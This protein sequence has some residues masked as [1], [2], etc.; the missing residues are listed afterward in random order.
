MPALAADCSAINPLALCPAHELLRA[1][2]LAFSTSPRIAPR[3]R[4]VCPTLTTDLTRYSTFNAR[5][6]LR[7]APLASPCVALLTD[8]SVFNALELC[9]VSGLLLLRHSMP[10][11]ALGFLLARRLAPCTVHGLLR[12]RYLTLR[13]GLRIAPYSN[14]SRPCDAHGLLRARHFSSAPPQIALCSTLD[15]RCGSRISP[16]TSLRA[17]C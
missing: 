11:A 7:I 12:S 3:L 16:L 13:A 2:H 17:R 9:A 15:A 8:L 6:R 14:T 10:H 5:F 4:F 1:R